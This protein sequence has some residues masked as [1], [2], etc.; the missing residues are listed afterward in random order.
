MFTALEFKQV[1][2]PEPFSLGT[3]AELPQT[4]LLAEEV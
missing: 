3:K 4:E 1:T 2:S